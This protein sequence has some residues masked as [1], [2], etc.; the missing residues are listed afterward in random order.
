VFARWGLIALTGCAQLAGIDSTSKGTDAAPPPVSSLQLERAQI[1]KTITR[2]PQDLT[3]LTAT[4]LIA[5]AAAP[6][7]LRRVPANLQGL[8]TW[9]ADLQREV[10]PVMFESPEL[11][12][13][14]VRIFDFPTPTLKAAVNVLEK[15]LAEAAIPNATLTFSIA[16][17]TAHNVESYQ[18]FTIGAWAN[19]GLTAPAV[20]AGTLAPPALALVAANSPIRRLDKFTLDD[21]VMLLRYSGNQLTAALNAMPFEQAMNNTVTGAFTAVA[22]NQTLNVTINQPA[23][24]TRIGLPR[25]AFGAPSFV[26]RL[27]ASPGADRNIQNGPQLHAA[28]VLAT[29]PQT[30]NV[31]Y[32]NPFSADFK[33]LLTWNVSATRT[34]TNNMVTATLSTGLFQRAEPTPGLALSL[35]AGM[36]DRILANTTVLNIDNATLVAPVNAPVEITFT[37]D[38]PQNTMYNVELYELVPNGMTYTLTKLVTTSALQPRGVIPREL[39][40]DG[41]LYMVRAITFQGCYTGL[42]EGDLTQMSLPCAQGFA[43][44]GVFQVVTQ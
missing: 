18:V 1:H 30:V 29:D 9:S 4:Y 32:G 12:T 36:P 24:A 26:W 42:A 41:S 21:V 44:S 5:D 23:A 20:G 25:P 39:F 33:T 34:Y 22:L 7:G 40:R 19:V 17:N 31:T 3:N 43:D 13:T 37:T 27:N 16:L 28:S 6:G 15:P 14:N 35:P 10:A 11:P 38:V 2:G 8:D